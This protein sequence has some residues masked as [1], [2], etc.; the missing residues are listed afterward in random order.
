MLSAITRICSA[1]LAGLFTVSSSAPVRTS[2]RA[3]PAEGEF[4]VWDL[5][6]ATDVPCEARKP[7]EG[8]DT[9][10]GLGEAAFRPRWR[11]GIH[12][13]AASRMTKGK[14]SIAGSVLGAGFQE[15]GINDMCVSPA[16]R[17]RGAELLAQ[18]LFFAA[19]CRARS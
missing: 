14:I 2:L 15:V 12:N 18:D 7:A 1:T 4:G 19:D 5:S 3:A 17:T 16:P 10:A 8:K 9:G 13:E 11:F 6:A